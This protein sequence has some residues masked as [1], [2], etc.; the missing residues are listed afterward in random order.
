MWGRERRYDGGG[1]TVAIPSSFHHHV[2]NSEA[3]DLKAEE[4][5]EAASESFDLIVAISS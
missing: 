3:L 5:N 2:G 4:E 1:G